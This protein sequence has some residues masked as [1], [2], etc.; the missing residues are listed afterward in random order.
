MKAQLLD[1][2][3]DEYHRR[4]GLSASIA[5]TL[6]ERSPLH[7]YTEHPCLGGVR[8]DTPTKEMDRGAVVH[9][10]ALGK[11]KGFA[12]IDVDDWRTK[13]ARQQRDAARAAGLVPIKAADFE[14]AQVIAA[15]VIE[16]LAARGIVLDGAS[17]AAMEWWE[18]S[19][20]GPVQ[21]RGMMDHVWLDRGVVLDLKIVGCAAPAAVERAAENMGYAIQ[22]AAYRRGIAKVRP[23]L[24]GRVDFLFAFV[25]AEAP[26]AANIC[27]PDGLFRELGERRWQRAVEV[28]GA[29]IKTNTW[30]SYGEGINQISAPAWA[31]A[32]EELA[33]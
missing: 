5:T 23:E 12:V 17:E 24:A 20:S 28:W 29:C 8:N 32:R 25:E 2:T 31:L 7:A 16:Q 27:R 6:I 10:I 3:P 19:P 1:I 11:G 21:C 14:A 30:P 33:A 4:P 18:D 22:Q 15:K 13:D 9:E 26:Y